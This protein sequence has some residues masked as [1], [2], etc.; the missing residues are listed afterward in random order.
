MLKRKKEIIYVKDLT[1]IKKFNKM[2]AIIEIF[3]LILKSVLF[4]FFCAI[5]PV[6]CPLT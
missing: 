2:A 5:L 6:I 3:V 4:P 1:Y